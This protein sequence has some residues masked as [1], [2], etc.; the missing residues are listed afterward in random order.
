MPT[1][2]VYD[3]YRPT[4]AAY[5]DGTY[6]VVGVGDGTVTLLRVSDADGRRANTGELVSVAREEFDAFDPTENPDGNRPLTASTESAV[7][8]AYW[9]I[10]AVGR[11][12]AAH[13]RPAAVAGA[14]VLFGAF[15]D[16]FWRV[17]EAALGASIL[18]GSLGV[19]YVGSGRL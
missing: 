2:A 1:P 16:Q 8:T 5:P 12:L 6:R 13:P 17:P 19:A 18:V 3:H 4:D 14:F 9:S 10:R 7:Q 15:G 11:E